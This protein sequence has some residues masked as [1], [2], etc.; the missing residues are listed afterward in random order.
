MSQYK[1]NHKDW[2][3][4][5]QLEKDAPYDELWLEERKQLFALNGNGWWWGWTEEN[6]P[7]DDLKP[8]LKHLYEL[9]EK[10]RKRH[11]HDRCHS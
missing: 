8:H 10:E 1:N 7:L 4:G 6:C 11:T 9:R 2:I 5:W 3:K